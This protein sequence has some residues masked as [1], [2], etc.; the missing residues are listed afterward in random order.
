M[1]GDL[2]AVQLSSRSDIHQC[3]ELWAR[4]RQGGHYLEQERRRLSEEWR[5]PVRCEDMPPGWKAAWQRR[6]ADKELYGQL[7]RLHGDQIPDLKPSRAD[8]DCDSTASQPS[9]GGEPR[10]DGRPAADGGNPSITLHI[11]AG[12][13]TTT[14]NGDNINTVQAN[15]RSHAELC[16]RADALPHAS[17]PHS[18]RD[19]TNGHRAGPADY[20]RAQGAPAGMPARQAMPRPLSGSAGP[21]PDRTHAT[22]ARASTR[23][24]PYTRGSGPT[25]VPARRG[26]LPPD[27][28]GQ[29][30]RQRSN[31]SPPAHERRGAQRND[32]R[33]GSLA[34]PAGLARTPPMAGRQPPTPIPFLRGG[35]DVHMREADVSLAQTTTPGA[36]DKHSATQAAAEREQARMA[37]AGEQVTVGAD[38]GGGQPMEGISNAVAL[39]GEAADAHL[40]GDGAAIHDEA[41]P[42]LESTDAVK[43]LSAKSLE[44]ARVYM[45]YFQFG[46]LTKINN[47]SGERRRRMLI[48]RSKLGDGEDEE[49]SRRMLK[50][51]ASVRKDGWC[52][53]K[54]AEAIV[55]DPP[56]MIDQFDTD[57]RA[58]Y[59]D[60]KYTERYSMVVS[61]PGVRSTSIHLDDNRV[62]A[63]SVMVN[64]HQEEPRRLLCEDTMVKIP[65]G[66]MLMFSGR[67]AGVAIKACDDLTSVA[68]YNP[69]ILADPR[70]HPSLHA[71]L[72]LDG[73][74]EPMPHHWTM[75]HHESEPG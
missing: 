48:L 32:M 33:A 18:R 8:A 60:V 27:S 67:H 74:L 55:V 29:G 53:A 20:H 5:R 72:D 16:A 58:A 49:E 11:N 34:G 43:F 35:R 24:A 39:V 3:L 61:A 73:G 65:P 30:I 22:P 59:P 7:K 9:T 38:A 2:G 19:A 52:L 1:P 46:D 10:R 71:H 69:L 75:T 25:D 13:A 70:L 57:I 15:A 14:V 56:I 23:T 41:T 54:L 66:Q 36:C 28:W 31:S 21:G 37:D 45:K 42:P 63:A 4:I 40:P 26:G 44:Y 17:D 50:E 64:L 51:A 62:G 47:P 12:T 6:E 68:D